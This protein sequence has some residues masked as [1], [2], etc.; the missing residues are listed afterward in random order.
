MSDPLLIEALCRD[1]CMWRNPPVDPDEPWEHKGGRLY[2]NWE[3]FTDE[4]EKFA[5]MS[6]TYGRMNGGRRM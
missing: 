2:R 3:M 4:A 5:A 1:I 6:R